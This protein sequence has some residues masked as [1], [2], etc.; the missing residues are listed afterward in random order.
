KAPVEEPDPIEVT[1]EA[2]PPVEDAPAVA[3]APPEPPREAR[4]EPRAAPSTSSSPS[5]SSAGGSRPAPVTSRTSAASPAAFVAPTV[6]EPEAPEEEGDSAGP[7][8]L[9]LDSFV[10]AA[11]SGRLSSLDAATL[12]GVPSSDPQYTRARSLLLADAEQRGD[13]RAVKRYLDELMVLPENRY[14]S[15]FLSK[16][17][18][19]L[20][21]QQRYADA[22][23]TA[24]TAERYWARIPSEL[25]WATKADIFE[26]QA[27][28]AQGLFYD[29]EDDLELLDDAIRSWEKL[30]QHAAGRDAALASRADTQI[31]RLEDVRRRLE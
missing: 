6:A 2:P 29:S 5:R 9:D 7:P 15:V 11:R 21:N 16:E 23:A 10:S 14:N 20:V 24:N 27:A 1:E 19:L 4:P 8:P 30:K 3:E 17:A 22:L 28:A 13:A 25:I 26:V 12:Q 31:G 18:V